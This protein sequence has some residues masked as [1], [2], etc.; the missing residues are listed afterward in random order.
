MATQETDL[1]GFPLG[2]LSELQKTERKAAEV[3]EASQQPVWMDYIEK[4]RLPNSEVKIKEM[5]RKV[6]LIAPE[7]VR[8]SQWLLGRSQT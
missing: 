6:G 4:D 2:Q 8:C 5:I 1:Y 7:A 3:S